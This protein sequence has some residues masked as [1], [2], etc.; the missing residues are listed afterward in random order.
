VK[1]ISQSHGLHL[2]SLL[3]QSDKV[4]EVIRRLRSGELHPGSTVSVLQLGPEIDS[5][6]FE[7]TPPALDLMRAIKRQFDPE[8]ILNPGKFF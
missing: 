1:S 8:N 6:P 4:T 2:V 3:G 7:V 5:V